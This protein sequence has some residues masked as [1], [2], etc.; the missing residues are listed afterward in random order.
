MLTEIE[1]QEIIRKS[2]SDYAS[3]LVMVW[4]KDGGLRICTDFRWLNARTHKN[5]HP[6][7]HQSD[8]LAALGGNTYF[9][10]MDLT[11]GFYSIPMCEEDKKYTAFTIS[12]GLHE[13]N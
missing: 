4:K 2:V 1:E 3:P 10:T 6:L 9:S 12:L 8:S 7:P 5:A 13:Y 11:S